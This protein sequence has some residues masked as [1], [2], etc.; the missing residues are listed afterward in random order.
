MNHPDFTPRN[1]AKFVV[2]AVIAGN[3]SRFTETKLT[4]YTAL[5]EDTLTGEIIG[6]T[7]GW[8]V[9]SQLKPYTDKA[10]DKTADYLAIKRAVRKERQAQKEALDKKD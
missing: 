7:V 1:V 5:E 4:E 9:S 8:F 10:V 3:V 6:G 2:V